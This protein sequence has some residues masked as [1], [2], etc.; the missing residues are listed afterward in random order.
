MKGVLHVRLEADLRVMRLEAKDFWHPSICYISY[1]IT[2]TVFIEVDI[3]KKYFYTALYFQFCVK[4]MITLRLF[5]APQEKPPEL[6]AQ[7][8]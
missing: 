8:I 6:I 1:Y 3:Y 5:I 7:L 2:V 4:L